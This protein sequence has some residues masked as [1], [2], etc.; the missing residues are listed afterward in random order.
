MGIMPVKTYN[1]R[2]LVI[3]EVLALQEKMHG[4]I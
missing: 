4:F 3:D 2:I 1:N